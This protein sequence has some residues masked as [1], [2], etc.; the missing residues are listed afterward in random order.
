MRKFVLLVV[1]LCFGSPAFA[2]TLNA[3]RLASVRKCA[4]ASGSG[5]DYTCSTSPSFTL[6]AQDEIIFR[7]DVA[8]SGPA[9]LSVNGGLAAPI[10]KQGGSLALVAND[11]LADQ[12]V[13]L[14]FDGTNWQMQ[15]QTGNA[16]VA[17]IEQTTVTSAINAP[18][19]Y[20]WPAQPG[21][22]SSPSPSTVEIFPN[23][24]GSDQYD[25]LGLHSVNS[26]NRRAAIMFDSHCN[27]TNLGFCTPLSGTQQTDEFEIGVDL[28]PNGTHS[29]FIFDEGPAQQV[30]YY[31]SQFQTVSLGTTAVVG[32]VGNP[33]GAGR[34]GDVTVPRLNTAGSPPTCF[35]S[36]GWG[37]GAT[38]GF[39]QGS[40]DMAGIILVQTGSA[41][42]SSG[43]LAVTFSGNSHF[44]QHDSPVCVANLID[45]SVNFNARATAVLYNTTL[46]NNQW[47]IDNNGLTFTPSTSYGMAYICIGK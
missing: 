17:S 45:E 42:S 2:Q 19:G 40:T 23:G 7:A 6:A 11:F 22:G 39:D 14:I 41:P 46:T 15:G 5:T 18:A 28:A 32:G 37:T 27:S 43:Y 26:S 9:T 3:D 36:A 47:L 44:G 10:T 1:I 35:L 12:W 24:T 13:L 30:G 33:A 25:Q 4:A 21:D 31:Q 16:V 34:A 29:F 8:N 20:V 38:C